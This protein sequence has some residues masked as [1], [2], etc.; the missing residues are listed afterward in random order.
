MEQQHGNGQL[1][2]TPPP[3]TEAFQD[4]LTLY[5]NPPVPG[6]VGVVRVATAHGAKG[7]E[8]DHV[9]I[10]NPEL[11]PLKERIL[12]GGWQRYEE[13]CV[14]FVA[15][16][17]AKNRLVYLP[18]LAVTSHTS[19]LDLFLQSAPPDEQ[20][21]QSTADTEPASSQESLPSDAGEDIGDGDG[22]GTGKPVDDDVTSKA[23][24]TLCID[25]IPST[26]AEI[27]QAVR[28]RLLKVHPDKNP[29][30]VATVSTQEVLAA[31][32]HLRTKLPVRI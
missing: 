20:A 24:R 25:A 9:Y 15:V 12:L 32:A 27:D 8:A 31:R 3:S 26:Q 21:S 11:F 6:G 19:C 28:R 23:L 2:T 17:R 18:N 13:L 16:T 5:L 22:A 30:E 7:L 4:W 29:S 1:G 14:A 10:F